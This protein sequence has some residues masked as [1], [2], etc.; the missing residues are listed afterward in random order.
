MAQLSMD[1]LSDDARIWIFGISPALDEEKSR[2]LLDHV[3]RFLA[4]WAAHGTPIASARELRE[5][6]FL[7]VGVDRSSETSGCSIDRMFGTLR[8]LESL[9]GISILDANRVFLR[10]ASGDVAAIPRREFRSSA[11]LETI[12]FDVLAERLHEV[13]GGAWERPAAESWHRQLL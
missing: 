6:S 5:G 12:V 9:L 1:Q 8:N 7:V 2:L 3:D 13:R 4:D 10:D 11:T